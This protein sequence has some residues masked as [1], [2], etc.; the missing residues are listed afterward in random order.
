MNISEDW[1]KIRFVTYASCMR[2]LAK[3]FPAKIKTNLKGWPQVVF[4]RQ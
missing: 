1:A 2:N 4:V 3:I